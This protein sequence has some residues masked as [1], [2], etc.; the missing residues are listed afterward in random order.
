MLTTQRKKLILEIVQ[1][2]G[3]VSVRD[4]TAQWNIS[5]DAIRR[6]LRELA[7]QGQLQRVH[8]GAISA[9]PAIVDYS[10]RESLSID[11]KQKL[12]KTAATM[13]QEGQVIGLDGGTTTLQLVRYLPKNLKATIVT[14]SPV[15][16]AELRFHEHVDVI[17]LGGKLFKHSMVSIGAET[18]E[19][20]KRI[21][22]DIF[23]L[24]ATG[25][26]RDAGVT[27]GDWDDAAVKRAFCTRSA[28]IVLMASPEKLNAA[29]AY[30]IIP[31]SELTTLIVGSETAAESCEGFVE[32][33]V[34][35]VQAGNDS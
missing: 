31:V 22:I 25:V 28:E 11:T 23:F 6:D 16:A 21:H 19:S 3:Q 2:Q 17:V 9:S 13:I 27:T 1:K 24:G 10:G 33:G 12:G 15:I 30:Q 26:H 18:L 14:H 4:L 7:K 8:G 5:E 20:L 32:A 34:S 35:V 29:S